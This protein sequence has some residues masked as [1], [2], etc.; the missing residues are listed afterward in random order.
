MKTPAQIAAHPKARLHRDIV[1]RL[2]AGGSIE[3]AK[4]AWADL[5]LNPRLWKRIVTY[6]LNRTE[7]QSRLNKIAFPDCNWLEVDSALAAGN[8]L[9]T[10]HDL[11]C[12]TA[13]LVKDLAGHYQVG[14]H[15]LK[16]TAQGPRMQA[17]IVFHRRKTGHQ[18]ASNPAK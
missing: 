6:G 8:K 18:M 7:Q 3:G 13:S 4:R 11:A 15:G 2:R 17:N 12:G 10:I 5:R 9:K 1:R 16:T 14:A